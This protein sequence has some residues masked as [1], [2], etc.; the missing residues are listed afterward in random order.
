MD[1]SHIA[2]EHEIHMTALLSCRPQEFASG[3]ERVDESGWDELELDVTGDFAAGGSRYRQDEE[4]LITCG[5]SLAISKPAGAGQTLQVTDLRSGGRRQYRFAGEGWQRQYVLL[6]L[7]ESLLDDWLLFLPGRVHILPTL[8]H[9]LAGEAIELSIDTPRGAYGLRRAKGDDAWLEVHFPTGHARQFQARDESWFEVRRVWSELYRPAENF[10]LP[11]S[12]M[13]SYEPLQRFKEGRCWVRLGDL[14]C[15]AEM[16]APGIFSPPDFPQVLLL[17]HGDVQVQNH[18]YPA[19]S[20]FGLHFLHLLISREHDQLMLERFGATPEQPDGDSGQRIFFRYR[21][22]CWEQLVARIEPTWW[23]RHG[24]QVLLA[25][26]A[27]ICL[28]AAMLLWEVL[29]TIFPVIPWLL[30]CFLP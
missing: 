2:H 10:K 27:A 12:A 17:E 8:H 19:G 30:D 26:A 5:K 13:I 11:E 16:P 15:P 29:F 14:R 22:N 23:Q 21:S 18:I 25:C 3:W 20:P 7:R 24:G 9:F 1:R 4:L 28:A 6:P